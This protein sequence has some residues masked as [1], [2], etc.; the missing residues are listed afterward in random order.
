MSDDLKLSTGWL[1]TTG[2]ALSQLANNAL[3]FAGNANQSISN[4]CAIEHHH[5]FF[6]RLRVCVN[7]LF[8]LMGDNEHCERAEYRDYLR[9]IA[10]VRTRHP[11]LDLDPAPYDSNYWRERNER[12]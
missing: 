2:D 9:A 1:I 4:R 5:W 8:A 10:K 6:G 11:G 12:D 3:L 7:A